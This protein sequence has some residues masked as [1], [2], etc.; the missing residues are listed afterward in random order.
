MGKTVS[1]D[2]LA[3]QLVSC[4]P[5]AKST[6]FKP[7]NLKSIYPSPLDSELI[8][9]LMEQLVEIDHLPLVLGVL[10]AFLDEK[11]DDN[12]LIILP[13]LKKQI[14]EHPY[15]V[16]NLLRHKHCSD[17]LAAWLV[18]HQETFPEPKFLRRTLRGL[19]YL[20]DPQKILAYHPPIDVIFS[21]K[22]YR[23]F[24]LTFLELDF[25][26]L[27]LL[28]YHN[29]SPKNQKCTGWLLDTFRFSQMQREIIKKKAPWI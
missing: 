8:S 22:Y 1:R 4:V 15:L 6:F 16:R 7:W 21:D 14:L 18:N 25:C 2:I 26:P 12:V 9:L 20:E 27:E 11:I 5:L 10:L 24:T 17:R 28:L 3:T 29:L 23:Q 19:S 13:K